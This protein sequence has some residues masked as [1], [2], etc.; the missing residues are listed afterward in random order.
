MIAE[1]L[2]PKGQGSRDQTPGLLEAAE[3]DERLGEVVAVVGEP[4]GALAPSVALRLEGPAKPSLGS[5]EVAPDA[6]HLGSVPSR[7]HRFRV[8][9]TSRQA[10]DVERAL[11][12]PRRL[13]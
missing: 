7:Q 1:Q 5:W 3:G 9:S 8:A 13:G 2:P 4:R 12:A 11:V 10:E 6:K